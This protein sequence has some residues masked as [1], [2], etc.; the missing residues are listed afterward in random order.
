MVEY[1]EMG[2]TDA[3]SDWACLAPACKTT[4]TVSIFAAESIVA[5]DGGRGESANCGWEVCNATVL[6][7]GEEEA[8]DTGDD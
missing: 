8:T 3:E 1:E 6:M 5:D 4:A 7:E 2:V